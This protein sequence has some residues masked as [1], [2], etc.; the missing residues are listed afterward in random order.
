MVQDNLG[1]CDEF[2]EFRPYIKYHKKGSRSQNARLSL[3]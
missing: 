2:R 1:I 3:L